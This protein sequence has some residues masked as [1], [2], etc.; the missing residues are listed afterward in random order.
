M[1]DISFGRIVLQGIFKYNAFGYDF[2]AVMEAIIIMLNWH[3]KDMQICCSDLVL[4]KS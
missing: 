3:A 1:A 4:L 2:M